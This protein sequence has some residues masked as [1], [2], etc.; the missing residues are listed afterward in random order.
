[1]RCADILDLK[2]N[3]GW[4]TERLVPLLAGLAEL[5]PWLKQW[6]NEPDPAHGRADGGLLSRASFRTRLGRWA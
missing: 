2:D 3:H 1:M 5:V 6:H 4:R